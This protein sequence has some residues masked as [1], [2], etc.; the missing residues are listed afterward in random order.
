VSYRRPSNI[1]KTSTNLSRSVKTR[2]GTTILVSQDTHNH[3][4]EL[5]HAEVVNVCEPY[6]QGDHAMLS[7]RDLALNKRFL[8]Y[9]HHILDA[10]TWIEGDG[11]TL[12]D[13]VFLL[14]RVVRDVQAVQVRTIAEIEF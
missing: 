11:R 9:A 1:P 13:A 2:F 4:H 6:C 12:S 5:G 3:R 10:I 7:S 8:N 14:Q